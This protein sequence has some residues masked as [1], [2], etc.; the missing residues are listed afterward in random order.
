MIYFSCSSTSL[1]LPLPWCYSCGTLVTTDDM[2][3]ELGYFLQHFLLKVKAK[4]FNTLLCSVSNMRHL[5]KL[6]WGY[7]T[8]IAQTVDAEIVYSGGPHC[9]NLSTQQPMQNFC[10]HQ[11]E[12]NT[13]ISTLSS[14]PLTQ[15]C[16]NQAIM[17]LLSLILLVMMPMSNQR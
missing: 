3:C 11:S 2:S 13:I 14:S 9:T 8:D 6:I 16:E 1:H 10:F 5:Q 17:D 15:C 4:A 7:L 12:A